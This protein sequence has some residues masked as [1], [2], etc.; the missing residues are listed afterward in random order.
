MRGIL[1]DPHEPVTGT[2]RH[3]G[4]RQQ[5]LNPCRRPNPMMFRRRHTQVPANKCALPCIQFPLTGAEPIPGHSPELLASVV[6]IS[7]TP[8]GQ[9]R[10]TQRTAT[11]RPARPLTRPPVLRQDP[12]WPPV[13]HACA[14]ACSWR[15]AGSTPPSPSAGC[16]TS[17]AVGPPARLLTQSVPT[18]TAHR[19][20]AT[21]TR[22]GAARETDPLSRP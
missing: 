5:R 2:A 20:S 16:R 14:S 15:P 13:E 22:Q 3:H 10:D 7:V 11:P 17:T 19:G 1:D 9:T 21:S 8:A 4:L 6:L 12:G 18:P